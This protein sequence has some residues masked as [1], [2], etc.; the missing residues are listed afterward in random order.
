MVSSSPVV[1]EVRGVTKDFGATHALRGVDFDVRAGEIVGLLGANGAG[2]S[3]LTSIISGALPPTSG[4]LAIE[5]RTAV[6]GSV[7]AASRAG[8]ETIVQNPDDAL[9]ADCSVAYNLVLPRIIQ[10]LFPAYAGSAAIEKEARRIA[11]DELDGI[12]LDALVRD[13]PTGQRQ[14][15]LI[16]RSLS[17]NPKLLILDEPT[18]ALSVDEQRRLHDRVHALAEAGTAIIYI[19]HHLGETMELCDRVV[20]LRNGVVEAEFSRPFDA[21]ALVTAMLGRLSGHVVGRGAIEC[22]RG[23][24][25]RAS[26]AAAPSR[27]PLLSLRGVRAFADGPQSDIDVYEHEI[28]GITGLLGAGK[29]ELVSQI[30]G[31][32]PLIDGTVTWKGRPL[33]VRHPGQAIKRG[34]GFVPEDRSR[35]GEIPGWTIAQNLTL[36]DLG[37]YRG[38]FGLLSARKERHEAASIIDRL[39]IRSGRPDAPIE[40][41]SGGNRQ[42]VIVGR[43]VA[44]QSDLLI[45]DEPF[46]GI[47]IGARRDIA[48]MLHASK[49]AI[50]VSSD[51]EEIMEIADRVL[52]FANGGVVGDIDPRET[53]T[54]E[55]ASLIASSGRW[56]PVD[57]AEDLEGAA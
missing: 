9:V 48:Q 13:L 44:A 33:V 17:T 24:S 20:V 42:K 56:E 29:T 8:V 50:V 30:V 3:T 25:D 26:A 18:A 16:A 27:R 14:Q 10:G 34:I 46:R 53:T 57:A 47:D 7:A 12:D 45:F 55:L 51:P 28:L 32:S 22:G 11:G 23:D 52:V 36:P 1:L 31:A 40:S 39:H 54:E 5:G 41:L 2:K 43:W 35:L 21:A 19:T 6:L 4:S 38:P 49:T 37:R 15:V